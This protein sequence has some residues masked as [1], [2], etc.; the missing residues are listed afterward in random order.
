LIRASEYGVPTLGLTYITR[1]S[2]I[3][4]DPEVLSRFLKATLRGVEFA[5]ANLD[6]A[7]DIVMQHAPNEDRQHQR[8]MLEVE[9]NMADGPV[10]RAN[11]LGW[12]THEQWQALQDALIEFGGLKAPVAPEDVFSDRILRSVYSNGKLIWP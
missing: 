4:D 10:S 7:T 3:D 8:N 2:L 9:L 6:A 12:A 1:Q 11:G 5:R